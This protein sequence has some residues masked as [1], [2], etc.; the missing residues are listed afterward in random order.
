MKNEILD[1]LGKIAKLKN[2]APEL[3]KVL[4]PAGQIK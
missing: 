1:L 2:K 4:E 3:N